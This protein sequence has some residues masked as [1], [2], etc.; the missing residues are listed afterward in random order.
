VS[1]AGLTA[2]LATSRGK[3][4]G[5]AALVHRLRDVRADARTRLETD[6]G[7]PVDARIAAD[8]L[9]EG[10][11][12]DDLVVLVGGILGNPVRV[13]DTEGGDKAANALLQNE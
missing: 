4:T 2:A 13:E 10:V 11:D 9:V 6:V 1:L 7:D 8:G 12:E 5:I 3:A